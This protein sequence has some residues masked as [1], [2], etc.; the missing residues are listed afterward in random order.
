MSNKYFLSK[1]DPTVIQII[2]SPLPFIQRLL[3]RG[4]YS[5]QTSK[6]KVS[7]FHSIYEVFGFKSARVINHCSH[8][9]DLRGG[10]GETSDVTGSSAW[11]DMYI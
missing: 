11:S 5:I 7:V 4:S 2:Q 1:D 8:D 9:T 10:V 6:N 3:W